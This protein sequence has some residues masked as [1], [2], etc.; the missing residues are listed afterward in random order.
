MSPR[1]VTRTAAASS[2][3]LQ[4]VTAGSFVLD[5]DGNCLGLLFGG[6]LARCFEGQQSVGLQVAL[7]SFGVHV[8]GQDVATGELTLH[9][10]AAVVGLLLV[11]AV[12]DDA[13]VLRLDGDFFRSEVPGVNSDGELVR[14][15]G[16]RSAL[17][18]SGAD[19]TVGRLLLVARLDV[20]PLV[21]ERR[22][23]ELAVQEGTTEV[24]I[25]EAS[26]QIRGTPGTAVAEQREQSH[27]CS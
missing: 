13:V 1:Y 26:H 22:V 5:F 10:A 19:A 12:D 20:E 8:L 4:G 24:V 17:L 6:V 16:D 18:A 7:D 15:A 3:F 21:V 23:E 11:L 27:C 25:Q 9:V 14:S 2:L